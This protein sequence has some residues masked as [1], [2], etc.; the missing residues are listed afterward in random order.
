MVQTKCSFNPIMVAT[1]HRLVFWCRFV[2]TVYY[3]MV[4]HEPGSPILSLWNA[5][6]AHRDASWYLIHR[7]K[8]KPVLLAAVPLSHCPSCYLP[9]VLWEMFFKKGLLGNVPKENQC[10]KFWGIG[11]QSLITAFQHKMQL[12]QF[13]SGTPVVKGLED[14]PCDW[15]RHVKN[16]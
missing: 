5:M 14:R 4:K 13:R 3:Q 11:L 6:T 12:V 8:W 2:V 15:A 7:R 9:S 16:A 1:I 10:G